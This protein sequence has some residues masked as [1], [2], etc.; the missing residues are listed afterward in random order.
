MKKQALAVVL[1]FLITGSCLGQRFG[2]GAIAGLSATQVSGDNLGGFTK[3]GIGAGVFVYSKLSEK[4]SA[5]IELFYVQKGSKSSSKDSVFYK[6]KLHYVEMPV[7]LRYHY[8]KFAIEAGPALSLL[9]SATEEDLFSTLDGK[10]FNPAELSVNIGIGYPLLERLYFNW[11]YS[12]SVLPIRNHGP[13]ATYIFNK[14]QY[15][16]MLFFSFRYYFDKPL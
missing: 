3:A 15:S 4:T 7:L 11:R 14:G 10:P 12:N 1:L 6:M 8:K 9:I 16:S 2:G 5:Q 13:E